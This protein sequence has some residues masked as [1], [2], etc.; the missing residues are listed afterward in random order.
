MTLVMVVLLGLRVSGGWRLWP[1][2]IGI[3]AGCAIAA[4]FGLYDFQLV[5]Q[6]QWVGVPGAWFPDFE[7]PE[8]SGFLTLLP[9]V[10]IVLSWS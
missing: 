6:A 2:I 8:V 7:L 9:M 5:I 3:V 10:V 1:P 4:P